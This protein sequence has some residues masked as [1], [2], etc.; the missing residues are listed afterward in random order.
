MKH[1]IVNA[2]DFALTEGVTKGILL[3]H[4]NGIVTSTS[5]M[6]N[7]PYFEKAVLMLKETSS[8]GIGIHLTLTWQ[9]PILPSS[10]IPSLVDQNGKFLKR[11]ILIPDNLDI[12]EVEAELTAQIEKAL[13]TGLPITHLDS[14]HHIHVS[15]QALFKLFAN[16]AKKYNFPLRSLEEKERKELLYSNIGTPDYFIGTFFGKEKISISRIKELLGNLPDGVTELMCHP[17]IPDEILAA[18]SS[19]VEERK[20]ELDILTD[21][22]L[23]KWL[24]DKNIHLANYTIFTL[25]H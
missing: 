24:D 19:Y 3:A 15:C 14:H 23:R 2:D 20:L 7:S 8:I 22:N 5:L 16:L 12:A 1:L 17:G 25:K 6:V 10:R 11:P 18:E 21:P 9:K 4:L 13:A